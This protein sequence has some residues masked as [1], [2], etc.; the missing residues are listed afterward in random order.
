MRRAR[1]VRRRADAL[2][3]AASSLED[4]RRM[5]L[6]YREFFQAF[7]ALAGRELTWPDGQA[8]YVVL[9]A[10]AGGAADGTRQKRLEDAVGGGCRVAAP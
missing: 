5:L 10:G 2:A 9:R 4:E 6:R 8:F 3:A 7:E 1:R